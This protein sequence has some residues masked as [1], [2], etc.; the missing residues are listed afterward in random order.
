MLRYS[1]FTKSISNMQ[2]IELNFSIKFVIT[3]EIREKIQE[4]LGDIPTKVL[5]SQLLIASRL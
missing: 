1:I 2:I 3:R 5:I 4:N